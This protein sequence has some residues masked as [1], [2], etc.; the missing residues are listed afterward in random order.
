MRR[1]AWSPPERD[2][3]RPLESRLVAE[4]P[5][6]EHPASASA[7]GKKISLADPIVLGGCA[8]VEQAGEKAGVN[9][10]VPFAPGRMDATQ[11]QTDV[12]SFAVRKPIAD[13]F[14][15]ATPA[16]WRPGDDVIVL[17]PGSCGVAKDRME[18]KDPNVT[19]HDWF[20]C[21]KKIDKETVLKK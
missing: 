19:C 10:K 16:D 18:G 5:Q 17:P 11:E 1:D 3:C 13:A 15:C 20:F 9:V 12:E 7:G 6:P 8:A 2:V 4:L 21:T 14:Q